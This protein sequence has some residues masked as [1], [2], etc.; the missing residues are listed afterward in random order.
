MADQGTEDFLLEFPYISISTNESTPA[1]TTADA[2]N[3][4]STSL[5]FFQN[6]AKTHLNRPW[7]LSSRSPKII[8]FHF[9]GIE[10]DAVPL[11]MMLHWS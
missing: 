10:L 8:V 1:M 7:L 4:I 5:C 2:I 6:D 9:F 11:G 3:R